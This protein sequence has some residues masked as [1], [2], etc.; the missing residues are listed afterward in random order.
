MAPRDEYAEI[1]DHLP[2]FGGRQDYEIGELIR[3]LGYSSVTTEPL[4]EPE[5]WLETPTYPRYLVLS[6]LVNAI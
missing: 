2:L 6:S 3:S 4:M 1:Y 5:L